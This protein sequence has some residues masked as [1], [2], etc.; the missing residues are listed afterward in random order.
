MVPWE[1]IILK[2]NRELEDVLNELAEYVLYGEENIINA[3]KKEEIHPIENEIQDN[4]DP[5]QIYK[6]FK[7]IEERNFWRMYADDIFYKQAKYLENYEDDYE[8]KE[9]HRNSYHIFEINIHIQDFPMRILG[10]TFLGEPK[11]GKVSFN[12]YNG[13]TNRF[14]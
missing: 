2:M 6:K 3:Y 4:S 8:I 12:I 1:E 10:H 9:I 14:I 5:K 7:Q 13:I 11:L